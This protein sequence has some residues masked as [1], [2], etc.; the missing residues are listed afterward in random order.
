MERMTT[1]II[2]IDVPD[3]V[4]AT[5]LVSTL[6]DTC[7]YYKIGSEL[8]TAAGRSAVEVVRGA[9][10]RVFLDLKFHDI[11]N[12]VQ[13]ACR[14]SS[15]MGA[16][17]LTV[18]AWGGQ[19]MISAAVEG[20]G[21]DCGVLAV[22]VLTSIDATEL[23]STLGRAPVSVADEV[24]RLAGLARA[25]GAHGVVCSGHE[26]A[27]LRRE[28]GPGFA[29]LVPGIRLEGGTTHDQKRV[30]T[31][32]AAAAAGATYLVIGRAVTEAADPVQAMRA[33]L[34]DLG[35]GGGGR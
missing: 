4:R 25:G 19:A 11:P 24:S 1:P 21:S 2:A 34:A 33:V 17:L 13:S 12:T 18:H 8:F 9:G 26:V 22:T 35:Q 16:S 10:K 27:R 5:E 31:P 23:A 29:L 7:Q 3:V 14:E 6:G 20:A 15:A 28:C 32:G 30:M